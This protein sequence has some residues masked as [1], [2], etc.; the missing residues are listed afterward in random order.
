MTCKYQEKDRANSNGGVHHLQQPSLRRDDVQ[1]AY[2][3]E[4]GV[5]SGVQHLQQPSLRRDDVQQAY[6]HE[7]G[8][9]SGVQHL[10]QPSLRRDD[11]QQPSHHHQKAAYA[12]IVFGLLL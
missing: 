4:G 5:Q 8:V 9:Q 7:G 11:N 12:E 10:Q 2:R 3:H 1:Q 6:R